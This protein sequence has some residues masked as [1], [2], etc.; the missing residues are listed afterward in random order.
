MDGCICVR[1]TQEAFLQWHSVVE[2]EYA[3]VQAHRHDVK[4]P[5]PNKVPLK[6]GWYLVFPLADAICSYTTHLQA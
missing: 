3:E 1:M 5:Q 2:V 4:L 6:E